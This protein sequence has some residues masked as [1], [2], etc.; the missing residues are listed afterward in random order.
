MLDLGPR[1]RAVLC[2]VFFGSEALLIATAGLRSDRSYGFRMFPETSSI[3]VHVSRQI[4]GQ[5]GSGGSDGARARRL[6]PIENGKWDAKDCSGATHTFVWGK[7]VKPPAPARLAPDTRFKDPRVGAPYGV[8]S[9]EHRTRDALQWV[10][11]HTPDDCE[12]RGFVA[13]VDP[14]RNGQPLEPVT[15]EVARAR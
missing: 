1:G 15:I 7:M 2:G 3:V 6:V 13:V 11:D 8:E 5:D 10:A 14:T 4:D 9:E 12:T